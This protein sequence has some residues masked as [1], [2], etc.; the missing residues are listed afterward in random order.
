[1]NDT[2]S[3]ASLPRLLLDALIDSYVRWREES[4]AVNATY[5]RWSHAAGGEDRGL[6]FDEYLAALDREEYAASAY[7]RLVEQA[8]RKA[9]ET[10]LAG[11][12]LA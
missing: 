3:H 1:M 7:R 9:G 11:G 4:A 5:R 12:A 2:N 8:S 10:S 6:R